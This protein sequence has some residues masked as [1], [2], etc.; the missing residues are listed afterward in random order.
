MVMV[1]LLM[2]MVVF[3]KENG[4]LEQWMDMVNC[5][6]QVRNL[7][8][9]VNGKEMLSMEMEKFTTKNQVTSLENSTSKTS[10]NLKTIGIDLKVNLLKTLKKV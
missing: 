3:T 7:H 6:I 10:M 2:L 5:I 9:K 1:N 4:D 8:M